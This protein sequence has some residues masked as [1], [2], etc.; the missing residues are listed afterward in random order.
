MSPERLA[1][2]FSTLTFGW[3]TKLMVVGYRKP[4]LQE[5]LWDLPEEDHPK[6]VSAVFEKYWKEELEKKK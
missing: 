3:I 5:D 6:N 4:L 1:N 2:F